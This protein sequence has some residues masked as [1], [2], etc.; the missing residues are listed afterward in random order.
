MH[1]ASASD[2]PLIPSLSVFLHF[3][4]VWSRHKLL[5]ELQADTKDER[6]RVRRRGKSRQKEERRHCSMFTSVTICFIISQQ[7]GSVMSQP[8]VGMT[9]GAS[10]P[11]MNSFCI[12][13]LKLSPVG[14]VEASVHLNAII[15]QRLLQCRSYWHDDTMCKI[16]GW[17]FGQRTDRKEGSARGMMIKD[18]QRA[19]VVK[20]HP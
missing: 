13:A 1:R 9:T 16:S 6:S 12:T 11:M 7:E 18:E 19:K 3:C 8:S 17:Y 4:R 20:L 2:Q 5:T 10:W 15:Y 14:T